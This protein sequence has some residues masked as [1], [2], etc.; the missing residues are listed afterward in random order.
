[1]A[2]SKRFQGFLLVLGDLA[3]FY[4]GLYLTLALRYGPP[5][6]AKIWHLH[7][8]PFFIIYLVWVLIFYISGLYDLKKFY[9]LKAGFGQ[10]AKAMTISLIMAILIFYAVPAFKIT[11]KTNL[12]INGVLAGFL[13]LLWRKCFW[14]LASR[15]S[16]IKILFFGYSE[17]A[18][19]LIE[20]FKTHPQLGYETAA[21]MARPIERDLKEAVKEHD[22]QLIVAAREIMNDPKASKHLYEALLAGI[23]IMELPDFYEQIMEKVPVS[24]ITKTW[25]LDNLF[26]INKRTFR[27]FKRFF[28]VVF[29]IILGILTII[30]ILPIFSVLIKLSSPGPVFLR[31]KRV[32][33]NGKI[34][35]LVKFRS[36]L[37]LSS[38]GSAEPEG[39]KWVGDKDERI[40]KIGKFIRKT[41]VD[42]LPQLWNILKGELSFIGPRPE[43]PEFIANLEKEIPYYIMRHLVKP[44]LSGWAQIK[45]PHGGAGEESMEKLQYDLYYIKNRSFTLDLAIALK[46]L[47]AILKF[48][49]R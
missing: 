3:L 4:L 46:T 11:P 12:I 41:R 45:L 10:I 13:L 21:I 14:N 33:K 19:T 25:F 43:R 1:M 30:V 44:G 32:G 9:S 42:E 34:F 35:N 37:A 26:E 22:I 7:Q 16:K 31:Q 6:P 18:K 20:S 2:F 48:E 40:T 47:A 15:A 49:G 28:D 27:F 8:L 24:I 38:D 39:A 29:S 23:S 5:I 36:M 17:E